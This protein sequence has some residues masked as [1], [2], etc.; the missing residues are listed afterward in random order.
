MWNCWLNLPGNISFV[1]DICS[2]WE[3]ILLVRF[4]K[5]FFSFFAMIVNGLGLY[6]VDALALDLHLIEVVVLVE[7]L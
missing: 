5:S 7:I 1:L 4:G 3:I 6:F 2:F